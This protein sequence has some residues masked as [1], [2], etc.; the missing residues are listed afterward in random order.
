MSDENTA[1][2]PDAA[3]AAPPEGNAD[4]LPQWARD[5]IAKANKEAA[6]YRTKVRDLEPLAKKARDLEDASKS[7]L[8]KAT[9]RLTAAEKRAAE[10]E[11][12]AMRL[13]V[14]AS[15][16]LTPAQA[17]RLVG[18]TLEELEAD[19]D[20][21]LATFGGKPADEDR[22]PTPRRPAANLK[23]GATPVAEQ[24]ESDP[25]KLALAARE[26]VGR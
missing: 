23:P 13:E 7:E 15:K 21:L 16:G 5:A 18:S 3:D 12:R 4:D 25:R 22:P 9:E 6:A 8:D 20:E 14:A 11:L 2:D 19:A 24:E 1:P 17:R 10:A 26:R